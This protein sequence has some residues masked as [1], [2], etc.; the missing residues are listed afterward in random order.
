MLFVF[1][2]RV[3]DFGLLFSSLEGRDFKCF[4][5][6]LWGFFLEFYP[7]RFAVESFREIFL[8]TP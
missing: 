8:R 6:P 2:G 7:E 3:V 5:V 1:L 4:G